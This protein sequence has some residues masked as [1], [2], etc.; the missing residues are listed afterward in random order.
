MNTLT[1]R[2]AFVSLSA[3]LV[4]GD[5]AQAFTDANADLKEAARNKPERVVVTAKAARPAQVAWVPTSPKKLDGFK[6][7]LPAE[8]EAART[9][10]KA[11]LPAAVKR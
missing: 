9:L 10:A 11:D 7:V 3:A 6:P 4:L 1:S 2:T 5:A 8:P